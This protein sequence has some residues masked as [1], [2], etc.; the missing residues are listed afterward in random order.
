MP[1]PKMPKVA[2]FPYVKY[3]KL[4]HMTYFRLH[5]L[6]MIAL[7]YL[8]VCLFYRVVFACI[9]WILVYFYCFVHRVN[10]KIYNRNTHKM[11]HFNMEM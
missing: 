5:L 1:P 7:A 6:V 3:S 8:T 2:L 11:R 10:L 9:R 4:S